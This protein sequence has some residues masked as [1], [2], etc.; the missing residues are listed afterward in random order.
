MF[1]RN[2]LGRAFHLTNPQPRPM[3]EALGFLRGLGYQFDELRFVELRDRLVNSRNFTANA[4][5]AY[6]ATLED[7]DDTSLQLPTYDTRQ[8]Q[9][10][11]R[12]A[13]IVCPAAD[14]KLFGLY[15]RYLQ[16]IGFIPAP[17]RLP[18]PV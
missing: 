12:P 1:K 2:A 6:Q 11:L 8:T 18:A 3:R 10:E 15:L 14:E 7:M 9:R 13:G 17:A 4:L 5:F 16:D